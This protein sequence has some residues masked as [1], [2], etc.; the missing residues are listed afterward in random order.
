MQHQLDPEDI[1]PQQIKACAAA[2]WVGFPEHDLD[3]GWRREAARVVLEPLPLAE[4]IVF[5]QLVSSDWPASDPN[6]NPPKE[7]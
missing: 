4:E 3:I 1:L 2:L 7:Q 5:N 6:F